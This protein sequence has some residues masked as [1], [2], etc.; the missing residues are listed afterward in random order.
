MRAPLPSPAPLDALHPDLVARGLRLLQP[1][2]FA[3]TD[4]KHIE[5]LLAAADFPAGARVLDVGCGVGR[6]AELMH[7]ARPDLSFVLLNF[8]QAQLADCPERFETHLADAHALP[9]EEASFDAVMFNAALGNMD[10][11]VALAEATRVLKPGGVLFLNELEL[12]PEAGTEIERVLCF[13]AFQPEALSAFCADLGLGCDSVEAPPV[14][15][16][17]LREHWDAEESYEEVFADIRPCLWRFTKQGAT[18]PAALAG[19]FFYRHERIALQVSGGKDSIATLFLL[20]PWWDRLAVCWL[21]PG[22]PVPETVEYMD[23]LRQIVPCFIEITGKQPEIVAADGWPSD[24]VPTLNTSAGQFVFGDT[25]FKIQDRL[26][27]CTRSLMVPLHAAMKA[28]GFTLLIRGKRKQEK[29]KTETRSGSTLDG[30]EFLYPVWD[31]TEEEVFTYLADNEIPLP[32]YYEYADHSLD[33]LSCTAWWGEG[34]GAYLEAKHPERHREY[35]RRIHLI[36][37]AVS[38]QMADCEV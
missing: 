26:S 25:G 12:G 23:A 29:D 7:E 21:N 34:L 8:S 9:F 33:C 31:W 4:A 6:C 36:K 20:R 22:D 13:Q 2:R 28:G 16:A 1:F 35:V 19:H 30:F 24:V 17:H 38:A 18:T 11:K 15:S 10:A 14:F 5:V 3:E 37:Q 32:G 27:C